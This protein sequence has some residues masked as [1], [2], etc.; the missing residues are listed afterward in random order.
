MTDVLGTA[1]L[2]AIRAVIDTTL[3]DTCA[4]V[5]GTAVMDGQGGNSTTWGTVAGTVNC[6]MDM[7]GG[8]EATAAGAVQPYST[9]VL[10]LTHDQSIQTNDRVI[11]GGGTFNVMS[12]NASQSWIGV[13]RAVLEKV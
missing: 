6:R 12:V 7:R 10:S 1:E 4:I 5:R 8:K 3:P 11:F 2:N 13:K 9:Y